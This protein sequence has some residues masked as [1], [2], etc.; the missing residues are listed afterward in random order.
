MTEQKNPDYAPS[1]KKVWKHV[2]IAADPFEQNQFFSVQE[3]QGAHVWDEKLSDTVWEEAEEPRATRVVLMKLGKDG[4][5][6][7]VNQAS[8]SG[9]RKYLP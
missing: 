2:Q 4:F 3:L 5:A 8:Y 1:E 9:P 7:N 6:K